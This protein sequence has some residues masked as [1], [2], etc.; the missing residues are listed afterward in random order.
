MLYIDKDLIFLED[1]GHICIE[2][3]TINNLTQKEKSNYKGMKM[4]NFMIFLLPQDG[5]IM[6]K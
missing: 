5:I 1:E 2:K 4:P 6:E 3:K